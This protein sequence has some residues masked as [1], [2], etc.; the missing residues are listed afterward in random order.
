MSSDVPGDAVT[1]AAGVPVEG[2]RATASMA[3][4]R[5][6]EVRWIKRVRVEWRHSGED[7]RVTGDFNSWSDPVTLQKGRDGVFG[8]YER[9]GGAAAPKLAPHGIS[10]QT[11]PRAGAAVPMSAV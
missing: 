7:V 9:R 11:A 10:C 8:A 2:A 3:A 4:T 6:S 1:G 5:A